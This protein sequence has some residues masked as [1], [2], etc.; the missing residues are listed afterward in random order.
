MS[1]SSTLQDKKAYQDLAVQTV[2]LIH[3]ILAYILLYMF[4]E[5]N[6]SL[7]TLVWKIL[8][9]ICTIQSVKQVLLHLG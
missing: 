8:N 4:Y 1:K 5:N 7:L 6:W 2:Y 3:N 9:H